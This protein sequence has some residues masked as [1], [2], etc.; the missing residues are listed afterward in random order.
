M[1]QPQKLRKWF[2]HDPKK[3]QGFQKKYLKEIKENKEAVE[4]L[5]E[6]MKEVE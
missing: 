4:T 6:K 2:D 1:H 3:C 5:K